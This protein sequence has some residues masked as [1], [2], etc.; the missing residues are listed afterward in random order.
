[1]GWQFDIRTA[2]FLGAF[3]TLLTGVLLFAVRRHFSA[4]LQPSLRWW[5]VATVAH[6]FGFLLIGLRALVS[7]WWSTVLSNVLIAVA[8]AAF[9]ISLRIFNGSPQRRGRLYALIA[10]TAA[11]ATWYTRLDPN[12][13][14]RI[15][16][17]SVLFA[18]LLGSSARSI[19]RKGQPRSPIAHITGGMFLLGTAVLAWRGLVYLFVPAAIPISPF[20]AT[21]LQIGVFALGGLLPV[22]ST[23]GYLLMCTEFNQLELAKAA[24]LD[25]LTG[26]CNRRAIEDLAARSIAAARRHGIP[27]AMMIIDV[28]HF[29]RINDELGHQ[30]GDV[31]LVETVKRIRDSLRSEDL[32]GRLGG[33]EFVA[34]MPSTDAGSALAA[35]E[36]MRSAFADLPMQ[37]D[38]KEMTV[39]VS[40][41]VAVLDAHDRQY[42]HLLR[43]AD[44]AMYGAKTAGRN[45]VMLDGVS[46]LDGS[47]L[48]ALS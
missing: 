46:P 16:G 17:I 14:L 25:Y 26:I 7:D 48:S 9:A 38:G 44:R 45:K 2:L 22:V 33:E 36:R 30:A 11:L 12:E 47:G 10:A 31:A 34:V 18:L 19:Y 37:I 42:A 6:P 15:G 27:M 40:V 21:P 8:F 35:A 41:G 1:M 43:R 24:N 3:L 20:E 23:I 39:T 13:S 28:D 32:V 29:K 5:I 4:T